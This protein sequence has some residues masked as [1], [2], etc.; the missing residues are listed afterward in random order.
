MVKPTPTQI[1]LVSN[2]QRTW[3]N[4]EKLKI[5]MDML[6]RYTGT[7][8]QDFCRHIIL[9]DFEYYMDRFSKLY[10]APIRSG[11]V[12]R[13]AHS[14]ALEVSI[15]DFKIGSP[16]AALVIEMLASITPDAV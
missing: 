13:C 14:K 16:T 5:A 15:V 7:R 2:R 3:N 12:M 10:T 1:E 8:S 4:P 11:S 6:E 9:T